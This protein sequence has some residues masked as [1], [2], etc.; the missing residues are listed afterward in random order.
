MLKIGF[1]R[2]DFLG[3]QR[4]Y[5]EARK[6]EVDFKKISKVAILSVLGRGTYRVFHAAQFYVDPLSFIEFGE[7]PCVLV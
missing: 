3:S 6:M 5:E 2:V 1:G 7:F 4:P